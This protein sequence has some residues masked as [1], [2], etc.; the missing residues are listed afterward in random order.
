MQSLMSEFGTG[1]TAVVSEFECYCLYCYK[2]LC[3]LLAIDFVL[4]MSMWSNMS[5]FKDIYVKSG[6]MKVQSFA[7][8]QQI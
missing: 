3:E 4:N 7:I 6:L 2:K 8:L 1:E 5:M